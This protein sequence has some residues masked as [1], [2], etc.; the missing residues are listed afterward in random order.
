MASYMLHALS[1]CSRYGFSDGDLLSDED[2]DARLYQGDGMYISDD[3]PLMAAVRKY[4]VP[5]L[6]PRVEIEEI[7]THHNPIRATDETKQFVDHCIV[8]E[9]SFDEI[10]QAFVE[11]Y[12]EDAARA[13]P[14]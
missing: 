3:L 14:K 2:F 13:N 5:K 11:Y 10:W 9:L 12:P 4:L 1:L 7:C 6:D 8:V